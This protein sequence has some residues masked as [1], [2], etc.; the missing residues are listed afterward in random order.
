MPESFSQRSIKAQAV[1]NMH[2]FRTDTVLSGQLVTKSTSTH[3][4]QLVPDLWSTHIYPSQL[5][6]V[7]VN[8]NPFRASLTLFFKKGL[9]SLNP[10]MYYSIAITVMEKVHID[11]HP[12]KK[13]VRF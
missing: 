5:V 7:L 3:F 11:I 2:L 12:R 10:S 13:E 1:D 9:Y 4:D 8:S 6:P